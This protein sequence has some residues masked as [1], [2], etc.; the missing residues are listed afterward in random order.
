[1]IISELI[2]KLEIH[3][4][5]NGDIEVIGCADGRCAKLDDEINIDEFYIDEEGEIIFID[6]DKYVKV[7]VVSF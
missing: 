2:K 3:K 7:L 5:K 6:N 4:E 1:M